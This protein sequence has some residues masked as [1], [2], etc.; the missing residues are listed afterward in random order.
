MNAGDIAKQL[1]AELRGDSSALICCVDDIKG[2]KTEALTFIGDSSYEDYLKSSNASVLLV[3][4]KLDVDSICEK[5]LDDNK[6]VVIVESAYKSFI[7]LIYK[8]LPELTNYGK[9]TPAPTKMIAD[10]AIISKDA[11]IYPNVFI[12]ENVSV[13]K[14][15]IIYPGAVVLPETIVGENCVIYPNACIYHNVVL[16]NNVVIGSG[17]SVGHDGFGYIDDNGKKLKIPHVGQVI[18]EDDVEIGAN[19]CIDRGTIT[20]SVIGRGSKLDNLIQFAHNCK[21]GE[22]CIICGFTGLSGSTT[23]G[24]NVI[25]AATSGTKGH[26]HIGDNAVVTARTSVTKDVAPGAQ[27]KVYPARPLAEELK[28]QTLIGKLPDIYER[29]RKLEKGAKNGKTNS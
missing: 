6:A 19:T 5:F 24:D 18:I 17:T 26:L 25:M 29:L 8:I 13:G 23:L 1:N 12:G 10:S 27:V 16:G 20:D 28:I 4:S 9:N 7:G 15:T 2:Q 21:T 22:N 3:E 14:G 11:V